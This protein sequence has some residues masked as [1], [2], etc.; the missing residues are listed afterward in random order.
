MIVLLT[1]FIGDQAPSLMPNCLKTWKT[2]LE[3][4]SKCSW[5]DISM[6]LS[7]DNESCHKIDSW[8]M[9]GSLFLMV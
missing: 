1:I 7:T 8:K 9:D 6:I 5:R 3:K 4:L 2:L